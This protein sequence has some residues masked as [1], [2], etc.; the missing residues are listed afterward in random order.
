[1][2][3]SSSPKMLLP[4]ELFLAQQNQTRMHVFDVRRAEAFASNPSLIVGAKR[5]EPWTLP[6]QLC[7]LKAAGQSCHRLV[8]VCVYGHAVSQTACIVAA[9]HG[10]DAVYLD[11]GMDGW[12]KRG[13]PTAP[14]SGEGLS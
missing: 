4:D 7:G 8:M 3:H 5:W 11:G 12:C 1:M 14:L 6:Q 13:L 9:C 10:F 2:G